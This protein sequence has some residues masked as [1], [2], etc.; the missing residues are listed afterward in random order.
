MTRGFGIFEYGR[1]SSTGHELARGG[2]N[3]GAGITNTSYEEKPSY[4]IGQ[5]TSDTNTDFIEPRNA[6]ETEKVRSS[7]VRKFDH[8]LVPAMFL[9]HL[10]FFL[11]KSNI[12]LARINGLE[13]DLKLTGNQ[14]NTALAMFF[15]LNILFNIPGNLVVR[16][17]GGAIWLPSLIIAWGLVTTFSGFITNFAGLCITRAFLGLTESS[18]L[19]GVLIYL[20]FFYT[21]DEL[22]L[23][24]GLF[25]SSTALAGFLGGL[26]AAGFGQIKVS[27][28]DGWPWIFFI[29]GSLTVLL[30]LVL[31]F[32]LPH[33]PADAKFLSSTEKTLAVQR[34]QT[35]DRWHYLGAPR[36]N[37]QESAGD[38]QLSNRVQAKKDSL[39]L[40]TILSA[41]GNAVT[42]L[43]AIGSFFSIQAIYSF[44]M[45]FP[46]IISAMGYK[47]LQASLMTA[48]PNF[49]ALVF[50]I[51]I[52]VWSRRSGKTALPLNVCSMT[53]IF[54]YVLMII[55]AKVGP[56]PIFM[57]IKIQYAGSFFIAM[58]VNATPPLALT[59]MSINASPH[60][61]RAV[62]LGFLLSIGNSA[63]FL[64]SFTYIKTEAPRYLKGQSI[65]LGCLFGLL[66]IGI[67]LPLYMRR[68]NRLRDQGA[69][70]HRLDENH[71]GAISLEEHEFRLGWMHPAFRFKF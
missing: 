16:S 54:G 57:N 24:V 10:L 39:T 69:R 60:Y 35:Q 33:T 56:A 40:M 49:A 63:A 71:R 29:E 28:Y 44:S 26:M 19:G 45:F 30:G 21:A 27:N 25:Y 14:F 37:D 50:T 3:D 6:E 52:S 1:S 7:L 11:D 2:N 68:E 31:L 18:F 15:I 66:V 47:K 8:R 5:T 41:I 65:N 55:G 32:V 48:P 62:A 59:W 23:R 13:R 4:A 9:A 38:D 58:S 17:V 34:M 20:G 12:A 51:G 43:M 67:V 61:I 70:D 42:I 53:G 22:I 46:T 36:L 64:A